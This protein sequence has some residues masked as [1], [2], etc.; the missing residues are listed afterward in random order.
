MKKSGEDLKKE[1]DELGKIVEDIIMSNI[2]TAGIP[3]LSALI[4]AKS[5]D[6]LADVVREAGAELAENLG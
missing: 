5:L 4:I 1:V 6:N 3:I 2:P